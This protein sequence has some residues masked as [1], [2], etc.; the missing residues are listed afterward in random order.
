MTNLGPDSKMSLLSFRTCSKRMDTG[1]NYFIAEFI[2]VG[3]TQHSGIQ[4][5]LSFLFLGIYIVTVAGNLGLVTIV[6]LNS[7]LHTPMY[8]FLFNLSS[9]DLCHS[10]VITPNC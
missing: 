6:G 8:H 10:S 3:L 2:P 1:N 4:L 7:H 9:I 5:T